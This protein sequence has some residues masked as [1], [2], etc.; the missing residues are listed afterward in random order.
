MLC[1]SSR[2]RAGCPAPRGRSCWRSH[3]VG[4][5]CDIGRANRVSA[6][7]PVSP[8]GGR[9]RGRDRSR[10]P[11]PRAA[12]GPSPPPCSGSYGARRPRSKCLPVVHS[13]GGLSLSAATIRPWIIPAL[14][15]AARWR[16]RHA[17][18]A[19]G[20]ARPYRRERRQ[21][22]PESWRDRPLSSTG[23]AQ[24]A[25]CLDAPGPLGCELSDPGMSRGPVLR[26]GTLTA[27]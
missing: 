18:H 15:R 27:F 12:V 4:R 16:A 11:T 6:R 25:S 17:P 21:T 10:P 2:P 3:Q 14:R 13:G 9:R 24:G 22:W 7:S 20:G 26:T 23:S 19:V 5:E 1:E 8:S